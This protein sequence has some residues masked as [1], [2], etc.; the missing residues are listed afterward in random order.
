M[1]SLDLV[2]LADPRLPGADG[3]C[4]AALLEAAAEAGYRVGLLA[5]RGPAPAPSARVAPALQNLLAAGRASWLDP[6]ERVEAALALAYHVRP[7]LEGLAGSCR[8]RAEQVLLRVDQPPV[9][10]AGESLFDLPRL[11][12]QLSAC[13]GGMPRLVAADPLLARMVARGAPGLELETAPWPPATLLAGR[14]DDL[15]ARVRIVGRHC[16]GGTGAVPD[17]AAAVLDAYPAQRGLEVRLAEAAVALAKDLERVPEGWRLQRG[18]LADPAAFLAGLDAYLFATSPAWQPFACA[19]LI[20]ALAAAPLL[21]LPPRLEPCFGEAAVYLEDDAPVAE[22]LTALTAKQI[23]ARRQAAKASYERSIGPLA[24]AAR[25]EARIGAPGRHAPRLSLRREVLPPRNVLFLSPN[26]IGM[27]HLTRLLAVARHA[28]ASIRPVFLSMSQ[29]VGVVER[30]GFIGEYFPYHGHTGENADA[31]SQALR[32]R[33]GEAIAFYDARCVVF[34]GNVPYQGLIEARL[35]HPNRPFVWIRRGMW[36]AEAGRGAIDRARH[37]D[38]VIEPGEFAA[39][40]DPGITAERDGEAVRVAPVILFDPEELLTREEAREELGLDPERLAVIVQLGSR[41][42]FD[43]RQVDRI[44]LETL[45]RRPDVQLVVLEWLIGGSAVKLPPQVRTLK[46]FPAAKYQRAFDFAISACGYNSFHELLGLGVPTILVP[47]ENPMMD[48][49]EV[50]A[51]W[52]DR[53]EHALCVRQQEPYR[54]AW[55][56][57]RMLEPETRERFARR[58]AGLPACDGA[59]ETARLIA[60]LAGSRAPWSLQ[61]RASQALL[62]QP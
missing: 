11:A 22:R 41:N 14:D 54:L 37:F 30:F 2:V 43:Y 25:L 1:L 50:R 34:D 40:D 39:E 55:A 17:S 15:P 24:V 31:W 19:G 38:L 33:L 10:A 3:R 53:R 29:A 32:A 42:N 60:E 62:R 16:L 9:D 12:R 56:L 27:G 48:A 52:A 35:D 46:V 59:R 23:A 8:V 20:E 49:Q 28:P 61:P 21:V 47:N 4:L 18:E 7:L 6:D 44:I 13:L 26:G 51:L 45:G 5:Q 36:R 57:E 58:A